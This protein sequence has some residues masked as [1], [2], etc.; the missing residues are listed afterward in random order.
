VLVFVQFG[1]IGDT[2]KKLI[3]EKGEKE[4]RKREREKDTLQIPKQFDSSTNL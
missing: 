4:E 1:E 2:Y 3:A